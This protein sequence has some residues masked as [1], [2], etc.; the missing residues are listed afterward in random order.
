MGGKKD[1]SQNKGTPVEQYRKNIGKQDYKK[2][3][4]EMKL[5]KQRADAK[6]TTSFG[7]K[8]E[9]GTNMYRILA[10]LLLIHSLALTASASRKVVVARERTD[11]RLSCSRGS[12]TI[13]SAI[14]GKGPNGKWEIGMDEARG[15]CNGRKRCRVPSQNKVFG[16]PAF[17][18]VKDLV[19][20][21]E[22]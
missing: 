5:I 6:S 10:L 22:C 2:S 18:V 8:V 15:R 21:Y 17:G 20:A 12:I 7:I 1:A 14:Y 3:K 13:L 4:K 16:D 9:N 11:A 19:I